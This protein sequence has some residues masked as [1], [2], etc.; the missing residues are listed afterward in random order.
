MPVYLRMFYYKRL[1]KAYDDEKK[2]YLKIKIPEEREQYEIIS[3]N[4]SHAGRNALI[5]VGG[6]F[7]EFYDRG[8]KKKIGGKLLQ[9]AGDAALEIV[10]DG[11]AS[12]IAA[13]NAAKAAGVIIDTLQVAFDGPMWDCAINNVISWCK[14]S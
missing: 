10:T 4:Q 6:V 5:C 7:Q 11:A 8:V 1:I 12:E 9:L 3:N 13:P 14:P 2:E